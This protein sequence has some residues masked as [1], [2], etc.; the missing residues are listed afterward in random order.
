MRDLLKS[1]PRVFLFDPTRDEKFARIPICPDVETALYRSRAPFFKI[2]FTTRDAAVFDMVCK[3]AF[4]ER[5]G[6]VLGIDE[7]HN[8]VPSFHASVPHWFSLCCLEGR[9]QNISIIGVTL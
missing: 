5:P 2:R 9:H 4:L 1:Q 6:A 8:Y 3:L 7:I